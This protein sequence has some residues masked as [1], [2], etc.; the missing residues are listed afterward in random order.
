MNSK[1]KTRKSA[2]NVYIQRKYCYHDV[3]LYCFLVSSSIVA[4]LDSYLFCFLLGRLSLS[5]NDETCR[6]PRTSCSWQ[7]EYQEPFVPPSV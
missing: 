3:P 1:K 2:N 5:A 7:G 6:N 4:F